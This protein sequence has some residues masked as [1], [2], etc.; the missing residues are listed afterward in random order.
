[1]GY[2]EWHARKLP[3]A[4]SPSGVSD[5][6]PEP[7]LPGSLHGWALILT[8]FGVFAGGMALNLTPCVYPL[9][10]IT[11]SYFGGRSSKGRLLGH[12]LCFIGGLSLTNSILGVVAALTGSLMGSILQNPLVLVFIAAML[13]LLAGSLFG[14]WTLYLPGGLMQAAAK[15]YAG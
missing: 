4:V 5:T 7:G 6:N 9:I 8:L 3:V 13:V 14:F 11:V 10:P 2:P 12:G 15:V 1:M